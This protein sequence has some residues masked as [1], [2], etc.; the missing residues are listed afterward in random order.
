MKG[1]SDYLQVMLPYRWLPT[2][3]AHDFLNI[4]LDPWQSEY[5]E[6][7]VRGQWCAIAGSNGLGKD[8]ASEVAA[9]FLI[10]TR[11]YLKGQCTGPNREQIFDV[12]W[13][14]CHHL[15]QR[16][17]ILQKLLLWEKTHIR[18]RIAPEEWFIVAKTA[19]KRYGKGGGSA[20]AEGIQGIRGKYTLV[21]ITEASGVEDPNFEAARSCC[22]VENSYFGAVGNPL[23]REGWFYDV[24]HKTTFS[25]WFRKNV[26]YL[27]SSYTN[28]KEMEQWIEEY[29]ED[30]AFCLPRCFGQFPLEGGDDFAIKWYMVKSA[31]EREAP[32][33]AGEDLQI[34]VDPARFGTD[35]AVIATRQGFVIPP[36]AILKKCTSKQLN[37][38]IEQ[39][40]FDAGGNRDTLIMVDESGL[41]GMGVVDPLRESP[42]NFTNVVGCQNIA[43]AVRA[44]RYAHWDDEQW[45][46]TM[47]EWLRYGVLP[48]DDL[49][50]KQMTN[51]KWK[52]TGKNNRQRKLESKDT[53]KDRMKMSPDRAEAVILACAP[54]PRLAGPLDI[55]HLNG[56]HEVS[57][58]EA[59]QEGALVVEE[60]INR[61]GIYWPG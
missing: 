15:M 20:Q 38:R 48:A 33:Q 10:S 51:R 21:L 18:C 45:M 11:P 23:R 7:L 6:R 36:L 14:G 46:D 4:D 26:S 41:G 40:V 61:S 54:D 19:S 31:M 24:F 60:A 57:E 13:A 32:L 50:L 1:L 59:A 35:E 3:W 8:W 5:V 16:S 53:Y 56:D 58:E 30:S 22:A 52:F 9:L 25:K 28:K 37:D 34:G 39:S 42:Y 17:P 29:G 49:L 2:K 47:P 43:R 12:V 44:D 27:E 55:H